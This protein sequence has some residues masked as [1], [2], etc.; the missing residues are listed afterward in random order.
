M[1]IYEFVCEPCDKV[2]EVLFRSMDE[3]KKVTCPDC[4]GDKVRKKL[5]VFG[6]KI[7]GAGG[8]FKSSV[9]GGGGCGT[10]SS[11][12]CSGCHT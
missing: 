2:F 4:G 3:R 11:S 9:G 10:C 6:T 12:S 8:S 1:P 5:S 7:A